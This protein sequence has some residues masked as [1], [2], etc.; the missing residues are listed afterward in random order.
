VIYREDVFQVY[1][2]LMYVYT[3]ATDS[4]A[5]SVEVPWEP[6]WDD[7]TLT[8]LVEQLDGVERTALVLEGPH[9]THLAVGGSAAAGVVVYVSYDGETVALAAGSDE[10]GCRTVVAGGTVV[11]YPLRY[12]VDVPV[13]VQA[14]WHFA[15]TGKL[16]PDLRWDEPS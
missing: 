9:D 3:I 2:G 8:A 6:D 16:D 11:D 1:E 7:A 5:G 14:A 4:P 15:R 10:P 13:A 12:V